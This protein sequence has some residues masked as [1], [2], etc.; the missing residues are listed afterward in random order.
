MSYPAKSVV[1]SGNPRQLSRGMRVGPYEITGFIGAGGMG[2]VY[3]AHDTHLNRIVALKLL[4]V[5]LASDPDRLRRFEE[6]ARTASALDH[7]AIVTIYEAGRIGAHPYISMELVAGETLRDILAVGAIPLRRALRIAGPAVGWARESA[8]SGPYTPGS[9][10]G[11]HQGL[12]RWF[13][14]N[15]RFRPGEAYLERA[16][17]RVAREYENCAPN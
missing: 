6:E 4:P 8:R 11:E 16:R 17:R 10:A 2:E 3:R 1:D 5:D 12:D 14:Q 15:P 9:E 7:P 13:R